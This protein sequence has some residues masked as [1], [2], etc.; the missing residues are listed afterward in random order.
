MSQQTE[1]QIEQDIQ[2]KGKTAPRVT[3][4]DI[5]GTVDSA[6]YYVFPG[7]T[8]TI[9][10]LTLK[11]G[12]TVVGHSAAVIADNFNEEIGR[13]IAFDDARDKIWPLEGYLL[14]QELYEAG[15]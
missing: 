7:T 3:P 10:A 11:N 2:A 15:K 12:F 5:D 14:R 1:D 9:C 6:A 8:L 4:T 13:K